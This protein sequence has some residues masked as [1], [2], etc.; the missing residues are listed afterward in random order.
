MARYAEA[1]PA[2]RW[3]ETLASAGLAPG[4]ARP[5]VELLT[6]L[7]PQLPTDHRGLNKL[8][9]L[10]RDETLRQGWPVTDP[11]LVQ[12]L[13]QLNGSSAA[14]KTARLLLG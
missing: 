11:V 7:L 5:V 1:W 4:G 12:W 9:D 6:A 8:L 10:L 14:A 2:N 13:G 3:A